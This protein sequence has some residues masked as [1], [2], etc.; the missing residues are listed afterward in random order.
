MADKDREKEPYIKEFYTLEQLSREF[1]MAVPSLRKFIKDGELK[2][3][4][5]GN[6]YMTTREDIT[7]WLK[8]NRIN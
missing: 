5:I 1:N 6:R 7:A 4:K 8:A 3:Y 2:A